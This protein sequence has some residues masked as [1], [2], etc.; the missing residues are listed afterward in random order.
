MTQTLTAFIIQMNVVE[1]FLV[2]QWKHISYNTI[3]LYLYVQECTV[4][5]S[6]KPACLWILGYVCR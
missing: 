3:K 6:C 2:T 5:Y 4:Y 1:L